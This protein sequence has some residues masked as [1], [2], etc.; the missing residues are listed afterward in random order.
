LVVLNK[1]DLPDAAAATGAREG[2]L[3]AAAPAPLSP[4]LRVSALTG[5]GI[6]ALREAIVA[7]ADAFQPQSGAEVIAVNARH[8]QALEAAQIALGDA[9]EKLRTAAPVELLAA[10]LRAAL[11]ALGEITGKVD[12]ERM[13]DHLFAA[14][15]I[16]K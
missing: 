12:N 11:V 3:T 16:G 13:L 6:E 4:A 15:C 8:A 14:F 2:P 1:C 10:D 9:L 7:R 5:E